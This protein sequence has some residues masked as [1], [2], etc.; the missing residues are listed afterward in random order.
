VPE[1]DT[2]AGPGLIRDTLGGFRELRREPGAAPL[3]LLAASQFFIL[4]ALDVFYALLAIDILGSGEQAAGLL[5]SA[6][7]IGGLLGAATTAALVGRRR[8]AGPIVAALV[9][10]GLALAA[11]AGA[12]QLAIALAL[13]V[14]CG[15]GR[16]FFDVATRTLLQRIVRDE[17]LA[18]VF[19]VQEALMM[20]VTAL[21]SAAVP[22]LVLAL[23]ERWAFVVAGAAL[24][25]FGLLLVGTLR[26]ADLRADVPDPARVALLGGID[27][28]APLSQPAVEQLARRLRPQ[29]VAADGIVMSEGDRGDRFYVVVSGEAVVRTGGREVAR[30]GPGAYVGEIALLR[31]VPRT[32][33]VV[34]ETPLELLSLER[35]EFLGAVTGART[36]SQAADATVRRRLA[37]LEGIAGTET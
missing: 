25:V 35:E 28:F 21:G 9:V 1:P 33:T 13:L 17:I 2:A 27:I 18:R 22:L 3:T 7:G 30:V 10:T 11:V 20:I 5:A 29:H 19:G 6:V 23:G 31:D 12:T 37:E 16:T 26:A 15:A 24:P 34:A 36:S 14:A 4:G 8:L 32:A